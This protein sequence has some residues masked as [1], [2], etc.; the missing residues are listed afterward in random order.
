[1]RRRNYVTPTSYL[2][3]IKTFKTLLDRKRLEILTLKDRYVIG[4]E[5][6]EM[7]EGQVANMQKELTD[8]QPKLIKTREETEELIA[9]I[10]KEAAEVDAVKQNVEA[11]TERANKAATEAQKIK[12]ECE[13]KLELAMPALNEAVN[14]LDTLKPQDIA[15][16][17][18][19]QNPPAGVRLVMESICIMK[20]SKPTRHNIILY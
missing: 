18:T 17:K 15:L 12:D 13:E 10:E 4:I 8:L 9:I 5:K 7:S 16:V 20:V 11:D 1:L 3:L 19:M 6:L 14:A 2:E